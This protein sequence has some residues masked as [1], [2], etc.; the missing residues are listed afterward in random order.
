MATPMPHPFDPTR[1]CLHEHACQALYRVERRRLQTLCEWLLPEPQ[2]AR[3][4]LRVVLVDFLRQSH[5]QWMAPGGH[6]VARTLAEYFRPLFHGGA[7]PLTADFVSVV[8]AAPLRLAVL[9]LP[10]PLRLVY[11]LHD[12]EH[13]AVATLAE[14]LWIRPAQCAR[15]IHQARQR[16]RA[17]LR[18]AA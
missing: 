15:L 1:V 11:L 6:P 14:W 12:C 13:Y 2:K 4:L 8:S 17:S 3:M 10:V 18:Q 16:L 9:N 5:D 7:V